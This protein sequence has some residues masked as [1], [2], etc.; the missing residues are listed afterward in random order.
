[1]NGLPKRGSISSYANGML[2]DGDDLH[3]TY[4]F[5]ENEENSSTIA[6]A[7]CISHTRSRPGKIAVGVGKESKAKSKIDKLQDGEE[8][9]IPSTRKSLKVMKVLRQFRLFP[10]RFRQQPAVFRS[11]MSTNQY[12]EMVEDE[13]EHEEEEGHSDDSMTYISKRSTRNNIRT[14][15]TMLVRQK[16]HIFSR[17]STAQAK[18]EISSSFSFDSPSYRNILQRERSLTLDSSSCDG[19]SDITD[20]TSFYRSFSKTDHLSFR[21]RQMFIDENTYCIKEDVG[22]DDD[23]YTSDIN[24]TSERNDVSLDSNVIECG[25]DFRK[26][27]SFDENKATSDNNYFNSYRPLDNNKEVTQTP[28]VSWQREISNSDFVLEN[29]Y[30]GTDMLPFT[31]QEPFQKM[32]SYR[33]SSSSHISSNT[34]YF[35]RSFELFNTHHTSATFHRLHLYNDPWSESR[36]RSYSDS[37]IHRTPPNQTFES[38]SWGDLNNKKKL[39]QNGSLLDSEFI[40][41]VTRS[42]RDSRLS[43]DAHSELLNSYRQPLHIF[44]L[45]EHNHLHH[46]T[47]SRSRSRTHSDSIIRGKSFPGKHSWDS[48]NQ[49]LLDFDNQSESITEGLFGTSELGSSPMASH[50]RHLTTTTFLLSNQRRS[51]STKKDE[52]TVN[53]TIRH[54][55][56][57]VL[58]TLSPTNHATG[59]LLSANDRV[60]PL[61]YSGRQPSPRTLNAANMIVTA[62]RPA[63]AQTQPML[64]K[65]SCIA[66]QSDNYYWNQGSGSVE[67]CE[68]QEQETGIQRAWPSESFDDLFF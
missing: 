14:G 56:S 22:E 9:D 26:L 66:D 47:R 21:R 50:T 55:T 39:G 53:T 32:K 58:A 7:S 5:E 49:S 41:S 51:S 12:Q 25:Y 37:C 30:S 60:M 36:D 8:G 1:M 3:M 45:D 10:I 59:E 2:D 4:S 38:L 23:E 6:N 24:S 33:R 35:D 15:R 20:D 46:P 17:P 64:P 16:A 62:L 28:T 19:L 42:K 65:P 27:L 61:K 13:H 11:S 18:C 40:P 48:R 68:V 63:P 44:G 29:D 54:I 34:G 52:D 67:M 43:L 57:S 31:N